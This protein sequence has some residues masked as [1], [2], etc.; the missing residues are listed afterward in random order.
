MCVEC[1]SGDGDL[2]CPEGAAKLLPA[3]TAT[4]LRRWAAKGKITHVRLPNGRLF[5]RREDI[6]ALLEPVIPT[7]NEGIPA[8]DPALASHGGAR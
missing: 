2:L 7:P 6:D 3:T 1:E 4:T 8:V 5:F